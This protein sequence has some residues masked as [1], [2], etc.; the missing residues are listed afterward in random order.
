MKFQRSIVIEAAGETIWPFLVEPEKILQW[1]LPVRTLSRTG[2]QHSGVG[3]R[4]YFEEK[5]G[6]RLLKLHFVVT[7]WDVNKRL[8]YKMTSGNLVKGYEQKLTI[9]AVPSGSRV[10]ILENVKLPY[11]I[12]GR[13]AGLFRRPRSES[14]LEHNL[15]KLKSLIET[16]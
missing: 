3:A 1:G 14:H 16:E 2:A 7:E 10:T 12:V 8:A 6:G 11:G 15:A 4:F 13:I 5:A 9:E